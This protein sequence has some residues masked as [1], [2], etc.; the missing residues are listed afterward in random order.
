MLVI[1]GELLEK[2]FSSGLFRGLRT[3][4][5]DFPA[6][7]CSRSITS[8]KPTLPRDDSNRLPASLQCLTLPIRFTTFYPFQTTDT[9]SSS[10]T[11]KCPRYI[12]PS[13]SSLRSNSSSDL[14]SIRRSASSLLF[15]SSL[16]PRP[17][18]LHP[19]PPPSSLLFLPL[20]PSSPSTLLD[21][22]HQHPH[23][24][25]CLYDIPLSSRICHIDS[26]DYPLER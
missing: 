14:S 24:H 13:Y 6:W 18:N 26:D 16:H 5:V 2:W 19:R 21:Q 20:L 4:M 1:V 23:S 12:S 10:T 17:K 9:S 8:P 7:A 11:P 22:R 25:L 3:R 15:S